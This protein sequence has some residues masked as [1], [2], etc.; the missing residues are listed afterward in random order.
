MLKNRSYYTTI[1]NEKMALLQADV[2]KVSGKH[3]IITDY[4]KFKEIY[5]NKYAKINL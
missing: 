4:E 3:L 1:S 5:I 2:V